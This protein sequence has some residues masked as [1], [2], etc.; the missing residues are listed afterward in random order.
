MKGSAKKSRTL[1]NALVRLSRVIAHHYA[2]VTVALENQSLQGQN[3]REEQTDSDSYLKQV[4]SA[5][6]GGEA[7]RAMHGRFIKGFSHLCNRRQEKR[8]Y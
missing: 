1:D 8:P 4:T 6:G 7:G 5:E 3:F 2:M